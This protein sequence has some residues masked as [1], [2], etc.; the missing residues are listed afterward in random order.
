MNIYF[1][2]T[3][4]VKREIFERIGIENPDKVYK[5][6]YN[7]FKQKFADNCLKNIIEFVDTWKGFNRTTRWAWRCVLG[8][9]V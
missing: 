6:A 1:I 7:N 2:R 8:A 3:M 4:Y 5:L 9:K